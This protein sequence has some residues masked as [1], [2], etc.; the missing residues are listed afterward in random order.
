MKKF[1]PVLLILIVL[2]AVASFFLLKPSSGK[3]YTV[4]LTQ[5]GFKP[6]KLLSIKAIK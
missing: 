5:D 3:T 6:D 1:V 2:A 4:T